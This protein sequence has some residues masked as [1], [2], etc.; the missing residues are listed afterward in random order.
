MEWPA[1]EDT[2][3]FKT[4]L[5]GCFLLCGTGKYPVQEGKKQILTVKMK[6]NSMVFHTSTFVFV[7]NY[8]NPLILPLIFMQE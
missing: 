6:Q 1:A 8:I 5:R 7:T 3:I 4:P 2:E